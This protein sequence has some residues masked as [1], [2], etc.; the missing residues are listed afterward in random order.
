LSKLRENIKLTANNR[1]LL[2]YNSAIT[3]EL[4]TPLKC[5]L[6]ISKQLMNKQT[7]AENEYNMLLINN[8][9]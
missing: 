9:A 3:H 1:M 4:I 2:I 6:E 7:N 5:M 8:T